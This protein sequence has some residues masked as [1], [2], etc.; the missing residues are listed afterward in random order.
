MSSGGASAAAGADRHQ[1]RRSQPQRINRGHTGGA[2]AYRKNRGRQQ[3]E[4]ERQQEKEMEIERSRISSGTAAENSAGAARISSGTSVKISYYKY[5][6]SLLIFGSCGIIAS[7]ISLNSYEIVLLR[8]MIGTMVLIALFFIT[9]QKLHLRSRPKDF[10]LVAASGAA[11]GGNWMF[12][13]E[14]YTQVGVGT[15]TLECYCG[16]VIVMALSPLLFKEKITGTKLA[17]IAAVMVGM[18][19][20]NI[21]S[22]GEGNS[23]WG[24]FCGAMSALTY[25]LMVIFNKKSH[26]I[27]GLENAMVSLGSAFLTVA[28]FTVAKQG[29]IIEVQSSDWLP[30]LIIGFVN[31]GL[32]CFLYFSS[33]GSLPVHSV[34]ILGYLEPLSAVV[35]SMMFLGEPMDIVKAAGAVLI[36]GGAVFGESRI[37]WRAPQL[38][39]R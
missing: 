4:T 3:N 21:Q 20:V 18:L 12:L 37:G 32:G 29:F 16:P 15:S 30:I 31:A 23:V 33:I 10:F 14:G 28:V 17:G 22:L 8:S 5:I 25:A 39:G 1:R 9:R 7:F 24:V 26:G 2:G 19:L 6:A 34:S 13:Y 35:F 36:L 27:E 11:M 38:S